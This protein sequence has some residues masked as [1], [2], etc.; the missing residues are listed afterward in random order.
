MQRLL[1]TALNASLP[2]VYLV[3]PRPV[4]P[5]PSLQGP[6]AVLPPRLH[7]LPLLPFPFIYIVLKRFNVS[8]ID[9]VLFQAFAVT[10]S[11]VSV[12]NLKQQ[13]TNVREI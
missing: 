1:A 7:R 3:L 9:F 5:P 4:Q 2:P 12:L 10:L 6:D 13:R 8:R 11:G